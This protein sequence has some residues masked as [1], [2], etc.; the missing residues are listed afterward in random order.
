MKKIFLS[1]I[2]LILS[3]FFLVYAQKKYY[4]QLTLPTKLYQNDHN[5]IPDSK[6]TQFNPGPI[7]LESIFQKDHSWTA[8]ISAQNK[9]TILATGDFIPARS[10]NFQ[11]IKNNDFTW[12]WQNVSDFLKTS[13]LTIINLESPLLKDCPVTN[14]G[15]I[16]CGNAEH[17]KGLLSAD[18]DIANIANNH[19]GNHGQ[20]G[21]DE[22]NQILTDAGI[23]ISGGENI[24][25]QKIK[26][27]TIAFLGY[28]EI[29]HYHKTLGEINEDQ[30]ERDIKE[31]KNAA[32][33]IIVSYHWGS[34][35]QTQ[36][37]KYRIDLAHKTIDWGA[38]LIIGNHP[39]WIQPVEIYK[40]KI[41]TY[42]HGNFIFDQEWSEETKRG[43]VG[44]YTFLGN[45]IIDTEFIPVFIHD[46]GQVDIANN[47]LKNQILDN[48]YQQ[49]QILSSQLK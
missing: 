30:I 48:M 13:D 46:Y 22:S 14:E 5:F 9:I 23:G 3:L 38:D 25:Y 33:M 6:A 39:H 40:D 18:I 44:K 15:M 24:F 36:P 21:I 35:Y 34:E 2:L 8:T 43:V 16:F 7:R 41:I 28:N 32:D 37:E 45:Q 42:A 31:A 27:K 10:V 11:T 12:A 1:T 4:N 20:E 17:I 19:Y 49:S 26:D 29:E 47:S